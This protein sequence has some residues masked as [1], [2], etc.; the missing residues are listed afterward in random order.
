MSWSLRESPDALAAA[1][2]RVEKVTGIP[3]E[4]VDK[5]SWFSVVLRRSWSE[6]STETFQ[7]LPG[8]IRIAP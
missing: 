3:M 7:R 4:H 2:T 6:W 5:D 8:R 1:A